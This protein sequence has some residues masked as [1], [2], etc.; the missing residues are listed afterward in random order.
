VTDLT[1]RSKRHWEAVL[2]R[3]T[4]DSVRLVEAC[5][6]RITEREA[7]VHAWAYLDPEGA[8]EQA[9]ACDRGPHRGVLHG[10]PIGV[11]D[12]IDVA[13]MPTACGSPIY[14]GAIA[15]ADAACVA[16]A[17]AAGA[18]ILG[19][20]HTA[21]F[22]NTAPPPTRNPHR[23]SH[24]PGGSSS[25]SAAAVADRMV[26]LAFGTQT[27]GST[28]RPAAFCGVV[29]FK[30]SL[31]RINRA[32]LK[33]SS[34]AF[35]TIGLFGR[36][37]A[38]VSCFNEALTGLPVTPRST[39]TGLRMGLH[40]GP[41]R[42]QAS[43]QALAVLEEAALKLE[44]AGAQ[45]IEFEPGWIDERLREAHQT[46]MLYELA[47]AT[48]A[49]YRAHPEALSARLTDHI[50][51]GLAIDLRSR[52][53]AAEWIAQC[54]HEYPDRVSSLDGLLTLAAPGPAPEGLSSTGDSIFNRVW[55]TLGLPCLALPAGRSDEG[56]PLA[57]QWVGAP[58]RDHEALAAAAAI[59]T[60]LAG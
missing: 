50:E 58:G 10:I 6:A 23:L 42:A 47:R 11:K 51:R 29:G 19:K 37:V 54:R 55:T 27:V 25:G 49:E 36:T 20:T 13:G 48:L 1:E 43:A 39:V 60:I 22:A 59:E 8:L 46:V 7:S 16:L 32:G 44:R 52:D 14:A 9:R 12:V 3:G 31:G 30:P 4:S 45:V 53:Q 18:I 41:F 15:R 17:R 40:R 24:T 33:F 56:L 35:D 57:V 26:P 5:L 28:I 21:E 2:R 34:E 38:E